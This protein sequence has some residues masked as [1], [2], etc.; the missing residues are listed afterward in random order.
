MT[1]TVSWLHN[2]TRPVECQALSD[3]LAEAAAARE[4]VVVVLEAEGAALHLVAGDSTGTVV[5]YHPPGYEDVGVGSLHSV[6]DLHL[7][8]ADAWEPPLTAYFFGHH[9]EFP[10]WSVVAH[11]VGQRATAQFCKRPIDAPPAV[12]WEPD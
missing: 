8:R 7:A 4:P 3:V 1:V 9:T 12:S 10:R 11:E 5:L 6:G 2:E